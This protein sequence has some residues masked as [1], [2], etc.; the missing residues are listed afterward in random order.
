MIT[1]GFCTY[2]GFIIESF[3]GLNGCPNCGTTSI[4]CSDEDQ[5]NV[6]I[7]WHELRTLCMWAEKWGNEKVGDASLIYSI[8]GRIRYQHP[9]RDSLTLADNI[10]ELPKKFPGIKFSTNVPGVET[11]NNGAVV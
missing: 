6:C 3:E 4:P 9:H 1:S 5:V 7:N 8:A 10:Q 2:C 11:D